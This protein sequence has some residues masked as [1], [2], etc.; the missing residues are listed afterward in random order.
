MIPITIIIMPQILHCRFFCSFLNFPTQSVRKAATRPKTRI[1]I[2]IRS[3][4][5]FVSRD[6]CGIV[7]LMRFF[8]TKSASRLV[9]AVPNKQGIAQIRIVSWS[10]LK[11]IVL[12]WLLKGIV[13]PVLGCGDLGTKLEKTM[14]HSANQTIRKPKQANLE[15]S[16]TDMSTR[17]IRGLV[18]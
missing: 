8:K 17:V 10:S 9:R 11:Y 13:W 18:D 14:I 2:A 15:S 3:L 1:K 6:Y 16:L 5:S 12:P 7:T 4:I